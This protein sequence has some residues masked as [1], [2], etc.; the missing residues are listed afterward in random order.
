MTTE[1]DSLEIHVDL[2]QLRYKQ[3]EDRMDAVEKEIRDINRDLLVFKDECRV[4]FNEIKHL[5]MEAKDQRFSSMFASTAT[6]IVALLAT[7]G[8]II[9][10]LPK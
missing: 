4:N 7:M 5:I 6:I 3:L 9:S 8:Y 1:R 2:C 10:H